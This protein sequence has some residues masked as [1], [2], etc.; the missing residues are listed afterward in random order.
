MAVSDF[1]Y[2]TSAELKQFF[3]N[4][5]GQGHTNKV[6][7]RNWQT[8]TT[9]NLYEAFGTGL[10]TMLYKNG[11]ELTSTGG[12]PS[13][14]KNF[15]YISGTDKLEY[16]DTGDNPA[17]VLMEAGSDWSDFVDEM[18]EMASQELNGMLDSRFPTPIPKQFFYDETDPDYD[19]VIKKLTAY[20]AVINIIRAD[21]PAD[22]SIEPLQ[23]ALDDMLQKLNA[24]EIRLKCEINNSDKNGEIIEKT[25]NGSMYLVETYCEQWI[26]ELYDNV[27]I[28]CT[29]LGVYG[30]AR[31]K[32]EMHGGHKIQG[33]EVLTDH[34]VTGGL[35][36]IGNG[37]YVR[38]EGTAMAVDDIWQVKIRR[39]DLEE[40]NSS[41]KDIPIHRGRREFFK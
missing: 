28:T 14:N 26:G 10:V 36:H 20:I 32:V 25:R 30:T 23:L 8:T 24:G 29:T 19:F 7:I 15:R 40:T 12:T 38:F 2:C 22:E 17:D 18:C 3:P 41:V 34:K 31:I 21:N 5:G 11:E 9:T 39:N 27:K 13:S 37:L 35:Q 6:A 4:I 1:Q 16:F 33:T